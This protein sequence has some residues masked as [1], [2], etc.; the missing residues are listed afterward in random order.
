MG[1]NKNSS[2]RLNDKPLS[3]LEFLAEGLGAAV[4]E[5][6]KPRVKSVKELIRER[7]DDAKEKINSIKKS[8]PLGYERNIEMLV[9]LQANGI[10]LLEEV[11]Y[12]K[13][14]EMIQTYYEETGDLRPRKGPVDPLSG[15]YQLGYSDRSE[16]LDW[17]CKNRVKEFDKLVRK[18]L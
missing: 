3:L 6:D 11:S 16:I 8:L 4:F 17:Y 15:R 14:C 12:N 9:A 13:G 2:G 5:D 7:K 18:A 1:V 10:D